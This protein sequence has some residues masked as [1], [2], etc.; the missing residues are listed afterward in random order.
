MDGAG[1]FFL[2]GPNTKYLDLKLLNRYVSEMVKLSAL[3]GYVFEV[4]PKS[5]E[6]AVIGAAVNAR[7]QRA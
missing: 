2:T 1:K 4:V 5:D 3:Q 7:Q 6:I